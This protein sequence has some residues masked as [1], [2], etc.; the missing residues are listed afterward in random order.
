MKTI[1]SILV[2]F[3]LVAGI[4]CAAAIDGVFVAQRTMGD[5]TITQTFTLKSD[6]AK[7]TGS[8]SMSFGDQE[9]RVAEI[10]DGKIDGAKF[11]FKTSMPGREGAMMTTTYEGTLEGDVLKGTSTREG[12]EPRQFEAKRK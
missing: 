5:R 2:V 1:L 4:V 12:G 3:V 7:L 10:K 9:P 8:L 6:G 11:S